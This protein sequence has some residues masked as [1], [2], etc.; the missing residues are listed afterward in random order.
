MDYRR[1]II[2]KMQQQE[3]DFINTESNDEDLCFR[4]KGEVFFLSVPNDD[5]SDDA[6]QEIINQV[7]LRGLELLPLDFNV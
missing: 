7:E 2:A 4:H 3:C 1:A 6:W 5:I